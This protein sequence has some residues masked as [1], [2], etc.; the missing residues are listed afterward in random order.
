MSEHKKKNDNNIW[1]SQKSTRE[2]GW[3]VE[4][5]EVLLCVSDFQ[6]IIKNKLKFLLKV[7]K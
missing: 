6:H 5:H 3:E 2:G 1:K 7:R 4:Q